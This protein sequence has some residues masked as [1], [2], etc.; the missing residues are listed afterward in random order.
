MAMHITSPSGTY[1]PGKDDNIY[2]F[3][4]DNA[5][6]YANYPDYF[7]QVQLK[8]NNVVKDVYKYVPNGTT[9][10]RVN[11]K[12]LIAPYFSYEFENNITEL[13]Y[14]PTNH[15]GVDKVL[16]VVLVIN[17]FCILPNGTIAG[18]G[19]D[20]GTSETRYYWNGTS[21]DFWSEKYNY[22]TILNYMPTGTSFPADRP[23]WVGPKKPLSFPSAYPSRATGV[24]RLQP[25]AKNAAYDIYRGTYRTASA[26]LYDTDTH[27]FNDQYYVAC[28]DCDGKMTK[29]GISILDM[30]ADF[31]PNNKFVTVPVGVQQINDLAV[32]SLQTGKIFFQLTT[33]GAS[34]GSERY[35]DDKD[36]YYQV[37][38][39]KSNV[40]FENQANSTIPLTFRIVEGKNDRRF[41]NYIDILYYSKLGAWW[42]IPAYKR[43]YKETSI[44]TDSYALTDTIAKTPSSRNRKTVHVEATDEYVVNTGW[45]NTYQISE[46]ED[47]IQSPTIDLC[48]G[49]VNI[50]VS[51]TDSSYTIDT[52]D[53][54][55]LKTY[56]FKFKTDYNKQVIR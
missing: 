49:G 44:K 33:Y 37:M 26:V 55:Y 15:S 20:S 50:P 1:L 14:L 25:A 56:T 47:M 45:L 39:M 17:A 23:Q 16:T 48:I 54:R 46:V 38:L 51:L 43:N 21:N 11:I 53:K 5:A 10:I 6:D 22:D 36:A 31:V 35:I 13:L 12:N 41:M 9:P 30:R 40:L 4:G 52:T 2:E 24:G 29:S 42:Q 32:T 28:Y 3:Y 7:Y 19:Q 34:I 27:Y 18:V 8:I